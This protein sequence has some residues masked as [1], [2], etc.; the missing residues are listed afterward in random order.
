MYIWT[1]RFKKTGYP[2]NLKL[3]EVFHRYNSSYA[4][5]CRKKAECLHVSI[6]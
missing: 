1:N 3:Y 5:E 6:K 4:K 2:C